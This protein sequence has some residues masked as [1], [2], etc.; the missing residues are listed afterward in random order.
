MCSTWGH[1]TGMENYELI[2]M[3]WKAKCLLIHG[4]LHKMDDDMLMVKDRKDKG[5]EIQDKGGYW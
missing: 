2:Q 4:T 3:K 5:R 1:K